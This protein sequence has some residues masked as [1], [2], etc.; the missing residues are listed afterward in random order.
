MNTINKLTTF[1]NTFQKV[2]VGLDLASKE[3]QLSYVDFEG[4]EHDYSLKPSKL[5]TFINEQ[6]NQRYVFAMEACGGSNFW[7]TRIKALG[8]EVYIFPAKSCRNY[9]SSK[10]KDDRGDARGVRNALLIYKTYPESATFKPCLIRDE[11]NRQEMYMVKSYSD[12]QSKITATNR[13]LVAFLKEQDA[14]KGYSYAMTPFQTIHHIKDFI[15]EYEYCKNKVE[16]LC[17]HLEFQCGELERYAIN[18]ALIENKF[19]EHY[20]KTHPSCEKY[21][22]VLGVG[23]PLAVSVSVTTQDDFTRYRNANSFISYMQLVPIHHGTGGKNKVGKH[24]SDGNKTLKTLFYEGGNSLVV[25]HNKLVAAKKLDDK[26]LDLKDKRIKI[27]FAKDIARNIFKVAN[28]ES[29]K[30]QQTTE[31]KNAP[32]QC[33]S[34]SEFDLAISDKKV[35]LNKLSKFRS[36]LKK[37]ENSIRSTLVDPVIYEIL[38]DTVTVQIESLLDS[39]KL[40]VNECTP[41]QKQLITEIK[42]C[43][44]NTDC[45]LID[46]ASLD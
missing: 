12:L 39:I 20:A 31:Q 11:I 13:N 1:A 19:F 33:N 45:S 21:L 17:E 29:L 4:I 10:N 25:A 30:T 15:S 14:L 37:L 22:S 34:S 3:I 43:Y 26:K 36:K 7:A 27:A 18:L 38:K 5:L 9:N 2:L 8:Y 23:I 35:A 44:W 28:D 24:S 42:S 41:W 46:D 16:G 32:A 40:K 6:S